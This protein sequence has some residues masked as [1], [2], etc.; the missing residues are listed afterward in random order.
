MNAR[1]VKDIKDFVSQC[2]VVTVNAPLHEGTKGLINKDLL[3]HFKK[4][5]RRSYSLDLHKAHD[6]CRA[7]GL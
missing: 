3:S 4:V 2:D 5:S 7:R 6:G 1:R